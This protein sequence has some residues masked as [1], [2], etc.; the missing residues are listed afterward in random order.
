VDW[1]ALA[2]AA[3]A[4]LLIGLPVAWAMEYVTDLAVRAAIEM[5]TR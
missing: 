2:V 3:T 5:R 1:K 4:A